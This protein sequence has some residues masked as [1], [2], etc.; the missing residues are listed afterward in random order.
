MTLRMS[1][2]IPRVLLSSKVSCSTVAGFGCIW[3]YLYTCIYW[4]LLST[5]AIFSAFFTV[6]C[7]MSLLE[8]CISVRG[9]LGLEAYDRG[10][11]KLVEAVYKAGLV[12]LPLMPVLRFAGA[13]GRPR[14]LK[15]TA[16]QR[17]HASLCVALV[18]PN[19]VAIQKKA[20]KTKN[21]VRQKK[22]V[23]KM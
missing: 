4:C 12:S 20:L 5:V 2:W 15:K 21:Y 18:A 8:T 3:L 10:G 14:S 16:L 17:H 1:F 11:P 22:N 9:G 23:T 7:Y 19:S 13:N 6:R